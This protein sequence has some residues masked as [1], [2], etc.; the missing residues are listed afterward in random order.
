MFLIDLRVRWDLPRFSCDLYFVSR[1]PL[2]SVLS[3]S[4]VQMCL[5]C[6]RLSCREHLVRKSANLGSCRSSVQMIEILVSSQMFLIDLRVRW[7]LPRFSFDFLGIPFYRFHVVGSGKFSSKTLCVRRSTYDARTTQNRTGERLRWTASGA[8]ADA[9][10][11]AGDVSYM[12]R[13]RNVVRVAALASDRL[14]RQANE[15]CEL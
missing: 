3:V 9:S 2:L 1:H 11:S 14:A 13:T 15:A 12:N 5:R 10:D 8:H 4:S 7:D 6:C